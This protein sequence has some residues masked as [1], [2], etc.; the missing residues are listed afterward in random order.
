MSSWKSIIEIN[1]KEN[2]M[3][4]ILRLHI[5][6]LMWHLQITPNWE[7]KWMY[8]DYHKGLKHGWFKFYDVKNLFK[9]KSYFDTPN[10]TFKTE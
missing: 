5:R 2:K 4:R 7:I 6:I 9:N 8:N 10:V 3:G 1:E